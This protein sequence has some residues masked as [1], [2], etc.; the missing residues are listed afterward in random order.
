MGSVATVAVAGWEV[1]PMPFKCNEPLLLPLV[2]RLAQ[3]EGVELESLLLLFR[4]EDEE[5]EGFAMM[6]GYIQ[7]IPVRDKR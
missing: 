1:L 5:E 4:K 6:V 7:S 3:L 2:T